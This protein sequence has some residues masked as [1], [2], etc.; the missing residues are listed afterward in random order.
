MYDEGP[1]SRQV[2][3]GPIRNS[4]GQSEYMLDICAHD[5]YTAIGC[6]VKPHAIDRP[7]RDVRTARCDSAG[8]NQSAVT[9]TIMWYVCNQLVNSFSEQNV[10]KHLHVRI[11]FKVTR[12]FSVH[13]QFCDCH[14][15]DDMLISWLKDNIHLGFVGKQNHCFVSCICA[16]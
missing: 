5:I 15:H 12:Y 4:P 3:Y 11:S 10:Y 2:P 9:L 8:I 13:V 6:N 7:T 14:E 1:I 16:L